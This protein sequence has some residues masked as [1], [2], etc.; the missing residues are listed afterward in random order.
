MSG[1]VVELGHHY[2]LVHVGVEEVHQHFHADTGG[3]LGT[4]VR[5]GQGFRH[6]HPGAAGFV[7]GGVV[8]L[9]AGGGGVGFTSKLRF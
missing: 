9:C 7:A 1:S 2:G 4:P 6:A 8:V 3:E 5:A